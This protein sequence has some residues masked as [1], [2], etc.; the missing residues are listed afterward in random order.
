MKYKFNKIIFLFIGIICFILL[1]QV[2]INGQKFDK[3]FVIQSPTENDDQKVI[4]PEKQ[5][6]NNMQNSPQINQNENNNNKPKKY[7][8]FK[9]PEIYPIEEALTKKHYKI[10]VFPVP[11]TKMPIF[12][13][14]SFITFEHITIS[15]EE[16]NKYWANMGY[17]IS[18][19][20]FS[21][22]RET[23]DEYPFKLYQEG[24]TF[25]Y[26]FVELGKKKLSGYDFIFVPPIG[27]KFDDA[28]MNHFYEFI[29]NAATK[30]PDFCMLQT[31]MSEEDRNE[32]DLYGDKYVFKPNWPEKQYQMMGGFVLKNNK[33]EALKE[34]M[35]PSHY[36]N[37]Y[38]YLLQHYCE[39]IDEPIIVS[40]YNFYTIPS[41]VYH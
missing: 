34:F 18:L 23:K 15:K 17:Y 12:P 40:P 27:V 14:H 13:S 28:F 30:H 7:E 11:G 1:F 37:R 26:D 38:D 24:I 29:N 6:D 20:G 3:I 8:V 32:N 41:N 31:Y 19:F 5:Q 2:M 25:H 33:P 9:R 35:F 21:Y 10:G 16:E 36:L 4:V 39:T 22:R